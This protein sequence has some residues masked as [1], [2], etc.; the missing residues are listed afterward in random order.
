MARGMSPAIGRFYLVFLTSLL[1]SLLAA[2]SKRTVKE[3]DRPAP[4]D[5]REPVTAGLN[6][7]TLKTRILQPRCIVCH[8]ANRRDGGV[9]LDTYENVLLELIPWNSKD[10]TLYKEVSTGSMPP[11]PRPVVE[12]VDTE[13]LARWIDAGAP[14]ESDQ[15]QPR[16]SRKPENVLGF[17]LV[18][19][20]VLKPSCVRCHNQQT[21]E[22]KVSY[23]TYDETLKTLEKGVHARSLLWEVMDFEEMPPPEEKDPVSRGQKDLVATWI[24]MGA[25][26]EPQPIPEPEPRPT[27][28]PSPTPRPEPT[29]QPP[30]II[31]QLNFENVKKYVIDV[32][33]I[34]C[35]SGERPKAGVSYETYE[36]TL[37]SVT[38]GDK[39]KSEFYLLMA[40]GEMPPKK[41]Q[42]KPVRPELIEYVGDWI[43]AGAPLKASTPGPK[44]SPSP[45]PQPSPGSTPTP[46]P[47]PTQT[48]AP[49]PTPNPITVVFPKS[50]PADLNY[51][52]VKKS[53]L[54]VACLACHQGA[55]PAGQVGFAD[56]AGTLK[57]LVPGKSAESK[58]IQVLESGAMPPVSKIKT[59]VPPRWITYMKKWIDAGAPVQTQPLPEE[60]KLDFAT[61]KKLVI[62]PSC[63]KCH[64][65]NRQRGGVNLETYEGTLKAL[66]QGDSDDSPL[67][68][69]MADGDMPPRGDAVDPELVAF[70][71][72]WVDAG[73]P[74]TIGETPNLEP[75]VNPDPAL[76]ASNKITFQ[77]VFDQVLKP[78]CLKCHGG[79]RTRAR[80]DIS[81]AEKI[82]AK[83]IDEDRDG[84][85]VK[86]L[87]VPGK[88]I[89][90][91]LYLSMV[92]KNLDVSQMPPADDPWTPLPKADLDLFVQW[93]KDGCL[94]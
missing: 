3:F 83:S 10:S 25:P 59:R 17:D 90:S 9:A 33:C 74:L 53:V 30:I 27:P 44:P 40:E 48:P 46:L 71:A 23:A 61:V 67:V 49:T 93:A 41:K 51:Q 12:E 26:K 37:E 70:V 39:E 86:G 81:S 57:T 18:Y 80:I 82:L 60:R 54:D 47:T 42:L 13:F 50:V 58:L 45:N 20:K 8:N 87:C 62:E 31:T 16:P 5:R 64:N 78:N 63:L 22:G 55:T 52:V 2:C 84:Q 24:D 34:D 4:G 94:P 91:L 68:Y 89:E 35:H 65:N 38:K 11:K 88:P 1:F 73:A 29:P 32:S 66:I 28:E 19:E 36:K 85:Q 6:F 56:Y 75:P 21:A 14:L 69:T 43:T 15:P 7:E 72:K 76:P 79:A 77:K 92:G